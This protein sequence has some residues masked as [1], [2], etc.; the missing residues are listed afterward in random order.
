MKHWDDSETS[1]GPVLNYYSFI[2]I[3]ELRKTTKNLSPGS[4]SPAG[5][6]TV[7]SLI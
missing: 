2:R 3:E 6:R 4:Q 7:Y 5:I 1:K